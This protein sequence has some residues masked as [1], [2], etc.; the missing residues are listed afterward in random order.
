MFSLEY[1]VDGPIRT[2]NNAFRLAYYIIFICCLCFE[3]ERFTDFVHADCQWF[4]ETMYI[5]IV[6]EL[7]IQVK[8]CCFSLSGIHSPMH[9][10]IAENF[11]LFMACQENGIHPGNCVEKSNVQFQRP[12][13]H[14]WYV[15]SKI[16]IILNI[17][18]IY[19]VH[20]PILFL[21]MVH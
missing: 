7:S 2:V 9:D 21:H 8:G 14:S 19:Y 3:F 17:H 5:Y 10:V 20:V 18:C 13:W 11:Q 12:A 16:F 15:F 1:H 6:H 4:S